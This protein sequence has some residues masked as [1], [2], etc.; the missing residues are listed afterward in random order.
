MLRG[1]STY[2]VTEKGS[3]RN[4]TLIECIVMV[5]CRSKMFKYAFAK[6][7][8]YCLNDSFSPLTTCSSDAKLVTMGLQ[9]T[10]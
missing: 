4:P 8:M 5:V 7:V 6:Q 3:D 9:S 10:N 1:G 2:K